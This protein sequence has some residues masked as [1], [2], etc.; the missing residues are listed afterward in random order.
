MEKK[1]LFCFLLLKTAFLCVEERTFKNNVKKTILGL[2][3][4]MKIVLK[5]QV[6]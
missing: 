1:V 4:C 2:D 6:L 3:L 5:I